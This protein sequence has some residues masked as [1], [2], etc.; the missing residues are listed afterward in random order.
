MSKS[1]VIYGQSEPMNVYS[2]ILG[3]YGIIGT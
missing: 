2:N 1:D 3:G